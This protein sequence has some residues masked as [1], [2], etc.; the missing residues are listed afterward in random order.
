MLGG[1]YASSCVVFLGLAASGVAV[2]LYSMPPSESFRRMWMLLWACHGYGG[3]ANYV[4]PAICALAVG[5]GAAVGY[6]L[7]GVVALLI[8]IIAFQPTV[9]QYLQSRLM[10]IGEADSV[11]ASLG[12]AR[13][14][15]DRK[16]L[17]L[18]IRCL[19]VAV[20]LCVLGCCGLWIGGPLSVLEN[21]GAALL[22]FGEFGVPASLMPTT[23]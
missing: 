8:T 7:P 9:V 6:V 12:D 16:L 17:L 11:S 22:L 4:V 1:T 18:R 15:A 2:W 3:L 5:S 19:T 14:H 20:T 23:K 13:R 10:S 21:I